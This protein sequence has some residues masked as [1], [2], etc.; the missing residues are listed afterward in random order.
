MES[1]TKGYLQ[2]SEAINPHVTRVKAILKKYPD[3]SKLMV[4]NPTTF[5]YI[6]LIV[7]LQVTMAWLVSSQP[8]WVILIAAY[9]VG[10]FANHALFV[11]THECTHNLIFKKR[12]YNIFAG[13]LCDLPNTIPTSIGFRRYHMKHHS[14]QGQYYHDADIASHWEAKMVKNIWW[15]KA[16]WLAFFPIFQ[17]IRPPRIKEMKLVDNWTIFNLFVCIV[18]NAA[19]VYFF[20]WAALGYLALSF[21]TSI[22]LHPVGARWIQEHYLIKPPQE[23][24]D[25]YG[26]LNKIQ[27]N[28]GYHNEHHDFPSVPWSNLPKVR[29]MAPEFYETLYYHKSWTKL[30]LQFIFDKNLSLY[31][32]SVRTKRTVGE[33]MHTEMYADSVSS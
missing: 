13:L 15:R 10:A 27:F 16:L 23:T 32:R 2:H 12:I 8:W 19:I 31:S 26:P 14:H 17:A 7:S 3:I 1:I 20:G 21:F 22:G 18:F 33:P 24:Y 6:I 25:Y 11:L 29:A 28:I 5:V 4:R 9:T 30:L